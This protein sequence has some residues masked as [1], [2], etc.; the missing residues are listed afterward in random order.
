MDVYGWVLLAA[1]VVVLAVVAGLFA[2]AAKKRRLRRE[3]RLVYGLP[4]EQVD[5]ADSLGCISDY[6]RHLRAHTPFAVDGTTWDDLD[7]DRVYSR[8]N[9]TC[10][11]AGEEVLYAALHA[12]KVDGKG[13]DDWERTVGYFADHEEERDAV[14]FCLARLGK[15]T[16]NGAADFLYEPKQRTL[17]FAWLYPV[18]SAV[19]A[20]SIVGLVVLHSRGLP[21]FILIAL[22]NMFFYYK[23]KVEMDA[24]LRTV[25]YLLSVIG[26]ARRLLRLRLPGFP[27]RLEPL[28]RQLRPLYGAA[29]SAAFLTSGMSV[30]DTNFL[31][32]YFKLFFML[33]FVLYGRFIR[34]IEKH[35]DAYLAA[36]RL[37]GGWDAAIAVASFRASMPR[38]TLPVFAPGP[39]TARDLVHPLLA[40]PVPSSVT[41]TRGALITG[42]NASGKSTF[43]KALAVNAIL[44]QTVHTCL[45]AQFSMPYSFVVTSMAVRDDLAAGE[46]YYIAEIRS[47]KRVVDGLSA[48]V[49]TFC[50]IDEILKGTNTVERIAASAAILR[51]LAEQD[52]LALVATHD[53]E[54]TEMLARQ[55]D[56]YHFAEEVTDAGIAFNYLL[57][58]GRATTKNAIKLLHFMGYDAAVT[59]QAEETAAAFERTGRWPG[60]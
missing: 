54:L 22:F 46:S 59:T 37:V 24:Q 25:G 48:G 55:Y 8:L 10:S 18:L 23:T 2:G 42:S 31:F 38:Y 50:V 30:N 56:N 58:K 19:A 15:F 36:Y 39:V 21:L 1:A 7:M 57:H 17:R 44:A 4:R 51:Y 11:S 32:E 3:L 47:L 53:I 45:A 14:R 5:D 33:D 12:Q 34:H 49:H 27:Q 60:L 41:L 6:W 28:H 40:K 29:R 52:C 43:V 16:A 35:R 26:C 13:L 9:H 20:L